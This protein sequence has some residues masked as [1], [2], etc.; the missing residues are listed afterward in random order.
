M[1]KRV[2]ASLPPIPALMLVVACLCCPPAIALVMA[3]ASAQTAELA[4]V[5]LPLTPESRDVVPAELARQIAQC[6]IEAHFGKGALCEPVLAYDLN[7]SIRAYLF[8]AHLGESSFA[9]DSEILRDLRDARQALPAARK[10]LAQIEGAATEEPPAQGEDSSSRSR[11]SAEWQQAE[12]IV[13]ELEKRSWGT[14]EYATVIVS[15]RRDLAPVQSYGN[16]LP[17][18]YT[19]RDRAQE[20]AAES[21]GSPVTLARFYFGGSLDQAFEF[22]SPAGERVWVVAFPP[23]LAEPGS[24]TPRVIKMTAEEQA[25]VS[26][27]WETTLRDVRSGSVRSRSNH[28]VGN[29]SEAVPA[30]L[31]TAGCTPTAATMVLA[32]WDWDGP[33]GRYTGLGNLNPYS[34][35]RRQ[36]INYDDRSGDPYMWDPNATD[37]NGLDGIPGWAL[38][39]LAYGMDTE[40]TTG[41]TTVGTGLTN[42]RDGILSW[43]NTL[44]GYSFTSDEQYTTWNW[45]SIWNLVR[46]E[47]ANHR[48]CVWSRNGTWAPGQAGSHSVAAIGYSDAGDIY[49]RSTWD[50]NWWADPYQ[51]NGQTFAHAT[52]AVPGGG[53]AG[54]DLELHAPDGGE[55]WLA[56]YQY[57]IQWYQWGSL[58]D[59]VEIDYSTDGGYTWTY[60]NTVAG[61]SGY[62]TFDGWTVP[63][64]TSDCEGAF[65]R[66]RGYDGSAL[67]AGDGSEDRF[68]LAALPVPSPPTLLSPP[69]GATRQPHTVTLDWSNVS[70]ATG[71][72]AYYGPVGGTGTWQDVTTSSLTIS[73]LLPDT[74]YYW[75]VAGRNRCGVLGSLS[76]TFTFMTGGPVA[77]GEVGEDLGPFRILGV[78]PNPARERVVI[79]YALPERGTLFAR[80][81]DVSGRLVRGLYDALEGP[82][83]GV[84]EWD[85]K[86]DAGQPCG[87]GIYFV[88]LRTA[89]EEQTARFVLLR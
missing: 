18:Y 23:R 46:N 61:S 38:Y 6:E 34:F 82:G 75:E 87:S 13:R 76:E 24:L 37:P 72:R 7:G 48:P 30:Y 55:A 43:T 42:V 26:E 60:I 78:E 77:V 29:F 45:S 86:D 15:A 40:A 88:R 21:L 70:W 3:S 71:Y 17:Y 19:W 27:A 69:N 67:V 36:I 83:N 50:L 4:K 12:R 51:G 62:R 5:A 22:E 89:V 9:D 2:L 80:I 68:T 14:D 8:V 1:I 84:L 33:T 47:I 81:Y 58:I 63:C 54:N 44:G 64:V 59:R 39:R 20:M 79:R 28:W 65:I 31:W 66:I 41:G 57:E 52:K 25:W 85:G 74:M 10:R 49:Y 11:K 32:Y 16:G 56:G 53:L 73:N 35:E